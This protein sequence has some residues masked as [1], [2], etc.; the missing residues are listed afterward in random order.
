MVEGKR[1]NTEEADRA[2]LAK[3]DIELEDKLSHDQ[4]KSLF[5][6]LWAEEK[7][8][9]KGRA[10]VRKTR[11]TDDEWAEEEQEDDM[12]EW[13]EDEFSNLDND[14]QMG[15]DDIMRTYIEENKTEFFEKPFEPVFSSIEDENDFS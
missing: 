12:G 2:L 8:K 3:D 9:I 11:A 6:R 7:K 15:D 1:A 13:E 14:D 10:N 5:S 4:I